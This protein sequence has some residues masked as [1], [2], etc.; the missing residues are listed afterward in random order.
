M[1]LREIP[2]DQQ[3]KVII[4]Y[5]NAH[6]NPNISDLVFDLQLDLF[7]MDRILDKMEEKGIDLKVGY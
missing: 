7:D 3:I 2:K 5:C 6:E 1:T 4:E